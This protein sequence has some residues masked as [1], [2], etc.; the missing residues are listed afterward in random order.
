MSNPLTDVCSWLQAEDIDAAFL[1]SPNTI[2]YCSGFKSEPHERVL[3]LII[4][5][6]NASLLICPQMEVAICQKIMWRR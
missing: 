3:A 6:D 4:L 2:F 1:T 5:Q